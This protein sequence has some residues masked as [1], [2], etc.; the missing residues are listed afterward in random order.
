MKY[1]HFNCKL[2]LNDY[3]IQENKVFT[4]RIVDVRN[5]QQFGSPGELGGVTLQ[6]ARREKS[7]EC[8]NL[9][10][11]FR[12]RESKVDDPGYAKKEKG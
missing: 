4:L 12:S 9:P 5:P 1:F 7:V 2:K 8:T 6:N 10:P 3:K 11:S